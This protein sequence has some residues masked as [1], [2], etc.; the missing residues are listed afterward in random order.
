MAKSFGKSLARAATSATM[1]AMK[2]AERE[3]KRALRTQQRVYEKQVREQEKARQKLEKE[4]YIES[5]VLEAASQSG[6]LIN[7]LD[8]YN[9][10]V[11]KVLEHVTLVSFEEY[12]NEFKP[13]E[14]IYNEQEPEN[15][16]AKLE[17][18]PKESWLDSIFSSRIVKRNKI[19]QNNDAAIKRAK[20]EYE[21][22]IEEYNVS[23]NQKYEAWIEE[24]EKRKV[25]ILQKN[26]EVDKWE[27]EFNSHKEDAVIKFIE[28]AFDKNWLFGDTISEIESCYIEHTKKVVIEIHVKSKNEIFPYEG[29]KH[30]KTK[31]SIEPVKM[32]VKD[33]TQR[34]TD[35]MIN[36]AVSAFY[37]IFG[38]AN[39]ENDIVEEIV[40]NVIHEGVCCISGDITEKQLNKLDLAITSHYDALKDN[41]MRIVKQLAR[42][43][44]PFERVYVQLGL[45][46]ESV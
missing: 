38:N 11:S 31:D 7:E 4:R 34:L 39:A 20:D 42:G 43:V 15:L 29:Y 6:S 5:R 23:K 8:K 46:L 13:S 22:K 33:A 21:Q 1:R 19:I 17:E 25:E 2:E 30:L 16:P 45:D 27:D 3:R 12:R 32:K 10:I 40:V 37:I 18:V 41:Y 35:L 24:E 14:F 44:K 26:Q 9:N 28:A 36:I